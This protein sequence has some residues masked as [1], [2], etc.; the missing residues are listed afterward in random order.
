[1]PTIKEL[2]VIATAARE[3]DREATIAVINLARAMVARHRDGKDTTD[4]FA[5]LIVSVDYQRETG[6]ARVIAHEGLRIE[7]AIRKMIA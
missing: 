6:Q 3:K 7:K 2:E 5:Q 1:M 4:L